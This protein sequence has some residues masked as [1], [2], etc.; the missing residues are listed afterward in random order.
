M[1]QEMNFVMRVLNFRE[2][3]AAF[4]A[5]PLHADNSYEISSII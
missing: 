4:C 1:Q 2:T 3:E 5:N